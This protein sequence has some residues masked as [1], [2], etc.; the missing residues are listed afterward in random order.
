MALIRKLLSVAADRY[1]EKYEL[2]TNRI[3]DFKMGINYLSALRRIDI[4]T[5]KSDDA[6]TTKKK[7]DV[8]NHKLALDMEKE[9]A[10]KR[11]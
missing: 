9:K 1:R 6:A 2:S 3:D 4:V 11:G 5:G 7:L 8:W 10:N